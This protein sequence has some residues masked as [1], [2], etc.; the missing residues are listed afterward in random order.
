MFW[1][2]IGFA[3]LLLM[4][5]F[6]YLTIQIIK[7]PLIKKIKYKILRIIIALVLISSFFI[8]FSSI[9]ALIVIIHIFL[10]TLIAQLCL[11]I[12]KKISKKQVK[13]YFVILLGLVFSVCYL[14][15]GAFLDYKVFET[16]YTI[17]TNKNIGADKFRI[18]QISDSHI[19]ATFDGNGFKKHIERI[20]KIDSDIVVITGDFVDDGTSKEDM[21][22]SCEALKL[23]KPK[24]GVYFIEGNHDKGY[25]NYRLF[26]AEEL[27][28]ELEKNGVKVLYDQVEEIN[29][30]IYLVGRKD[31]SSDRLNID[32][33]VQNLDK[34]KYI[35]DLNH[36]PNDYENE[37]NAKV[38]L[39][40]SGHTHGGQLFPLGPLGVLFKAN[41]AYYGMEKRDD[42]TFIVNSG[43]SDW[44][45][46][47]KTGTKSEFG[48]IDIVNKKD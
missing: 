35:I 13:E 33:L 5:A 36:Q 14:G 8:I 17:E 28:E 34:N 37:K 3:L 10:L 15:I 25:F 21:I 42:T 23:L 39:V 31:K 41:D 11:F 24:Y 26:S 45:V 7:I 47:F 1:T 46:I 2:L 4:Y 9:N 19:G 12:F 22:A 29:E 27:N 30:N 32:E 6:I 43:I 44:E 48:V 16:H 18:I 20:S 38:D 40:L